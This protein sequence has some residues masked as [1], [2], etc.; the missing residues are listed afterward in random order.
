MNSLE[1]K[2]MA[3]PYLRM[4]RT[5]A[6]CYQAFERSGAA[7]DRNAGLTSPQFDIIATLGNTEGMT[8]KELGEKTLMTKGTL[9][10]VLDRLQER[11]LIERTEHVND[12]RMIIV[13]LTALGVQVFEQT[14]TPRVLGLLEKCQSLTPL[15]IEQAIAVFDRLRNLFVDDSQE[16]LNAKRT[17]CE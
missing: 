11:G 12:G 10:G 4:I 3:W 17:H 1:A 15:E 14:Y 13:K 9:S 5:M 7:Q 2:Q 6:E 8:C 16:P